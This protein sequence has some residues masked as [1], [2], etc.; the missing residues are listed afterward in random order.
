MTGAAGRQKFVYS[1]NCDSAARHTISSPLE[2]HKGYTLV[3]AMVGI[4]VGFDNSLFVTT[5]LCY[6][7]VDRDTHAELPQIILSFPR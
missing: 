6:E 3:C 1:L 4:D 5:V 2:T 7:E